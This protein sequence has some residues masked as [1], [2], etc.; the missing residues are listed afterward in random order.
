MST[1][2]TIPSARPAAEVSEWLKRWTSRGYKVALWRDDG[3]PI[4]GCT[5]TM[6]GAYPGYA[7]ACNELIAHVLKTDP[8]CDWV[9]TGGDDTWPDPNHTADE[10]AYQCSAHFRQNWGLT[11]PAVLTRDECS[12][13][14]V[15]QPTG[16]DWSDIKGRIIERIAGSPWIGR[17][18][19]LRINGGQGPYWPEYR[20][21]WVDEEIMCVAQKL[22]CFWQRPDLIHF[23]DHPMRYPGGKWPVHL[24]HAS[25]DYSRMKPLFEARKRLGF[26]GS[27]PL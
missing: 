17:E 13:F 19:A 10:I 12:T 5:L 7:V 6:G 16:D 22:G 3:V 25:A 18:F 11:F 1:W 2:L 15:C 21:N 27:E 8:E 20:H 14:G 9:V 24:N 4:E 26:P 23:H